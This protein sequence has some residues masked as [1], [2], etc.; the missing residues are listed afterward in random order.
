MHS[1]GGE[2]GWDAW[3]FFTHA[4]HGITDEL[5]FLLAIFALPLV[6]MHVCSGLD[7]IQQHV[8]TLKH[9]LCTGLPIALIA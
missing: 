3:D 8:F 7:R 4:L 5:D 6:C 1:K 9:Y 2:K